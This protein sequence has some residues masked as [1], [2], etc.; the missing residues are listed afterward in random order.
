VLRLPLSAVVVGA[1]LTAKAG[2]GVV[3]LIIV[4]TVVSYVVTL[5]I[6][7]RWAGQ[8][9]A[10]SAGPE[11]ENSPAAGAHTADPAPAVAT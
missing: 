1:F 7:A 10:V 9:D 2:A 4:G 8:R 11:D 5:L 6:S 3:P